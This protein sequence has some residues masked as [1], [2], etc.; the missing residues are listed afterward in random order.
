LIQETGSAGHALAMSGNGV[1]LV[2]A[3]FLSG[4]GKFIRSWKR[5]S[6]ATWIP[7]TNTLEI[8]GTKA[9][10][11]S[12]VDYLTMIP[13]TDYASNFDLLYTVSTPTNGTS[14]RNQTVVRN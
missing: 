6:Q 4:S 13:A 9:S 1:Y 11:N 7:G 10:V 3:S 14:V 8:V 12:H 5:Q 2:S